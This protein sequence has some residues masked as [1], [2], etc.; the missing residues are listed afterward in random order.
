MKK[1]ERQYY[2][3]QDYVMHTKKIKFCMQ[4][5]CFFFRKMFVC[6]QNLICGW[7]KILEQDF[8]KKCRS[9]I[10]HIWK[11]YGKRF[12]SKKYF[13]SVFFCHQS[14]Q[15]FSKSRRNGLIFFLLIFEKVRKLHDTHFLFLHTFDVW[16]CMIKIFVVWNCMISIFG[17]WRSTRAVKELQATS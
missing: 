7:K 10:F 12:F 5:I 16:T 11:L 9:Y 13:K 14:V 17:V 6:V 1:K 4:K 2:R 15:L 3:I 8:I